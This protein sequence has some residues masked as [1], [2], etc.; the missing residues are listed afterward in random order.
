MS[1]RCVVLASGL[2][3]GWDEGALA[4]CL[5]P[6]AAVAVPW[7]RPLYTLGRLGGDLGR[8]SV[9]GVARA[10]AEAELL[11]A[12]AV[13]GTGV[14]RCLGFLTFGLGVVGLGVVGLA[15][16][17]AARLWPRLSPLRIKCSEESLRNVS[18]RCFWQ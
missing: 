3:A 8:E 16:V 14:T 5:P 4:F 18:W 6:V 10:E 2:A 13:E 17:G 11:L 15:V 1:V 9:M 12:G 7:G